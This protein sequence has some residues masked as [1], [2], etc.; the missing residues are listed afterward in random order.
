MALPGSH[1]DSFESTA[2][3]G[4]TAATYFLGMTALLGAAISSTFIG[5][6]SDRI[7]RKPC[8]LVCV[9]VGAVGAIVN[10]L[11]RGS[12]WG[13]CIANFAQGLFAA[14]DP[15]ALAYVS[16]VK[17]T[18]KEKDAEIGNLIALSMVGMT[19]GGV[20]SIFMEKQGL[21][22][23]LLLGAALNVVATIAIVF[24]V[25]EPNKVVLP[26]NVLTDDDSEAE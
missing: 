7:G 20:C 21:F 25:V 10:Y 9:G 4:V 26:A 3:F 8:L 14:S 24:C 11:A 1:P 5:A 12:F 19:G 6:L 15:V 23:P 13:F 2:P 22:A 16:D 18:R 17:A